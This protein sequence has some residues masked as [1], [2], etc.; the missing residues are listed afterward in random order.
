MHILTS[1]DFG[2]V[3][4]RMEIIAEA[5]QSQT[6]HHCFCAIGQGGATADRL[7]SL[8]A[9]V[10]CLLRKTSI[11]TFS[12]AVALYNHIRQIR[13]AVVHTHGA[14][15]NFHGLI[16]AWLARVPV[17]IGE[18]I[19]IPS[20]GTRARKIFAQVYRIAHRVVGISEAVTRWLIQSGEVPTKK[21]TRIYNP[22]ALQ[23]YSAPGSGGAGVFRIG[24]VGRLEPVKNPIALLEALQL[25][26]NSG[27]IAELWLVGDGSERG[28]LE[29]YVRVHGLCDQVKMLGFQPNPSVA[30]RECDVYVQPSISEGFGLA[31]VEAMG[32]GMPVIATAVGGAP[33]VIEHGRTGWLLEGATPEAIGEAIGHVARMTSV[34]REAVGRAAAEAVHGRFEPAAYLYE[35]ESLYLQLLDQRNGLR[36]G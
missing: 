33:E 17:R 22:V 24:F 7:V 11:P 13:P 34:D 31:L 23:Q 36:I 14:E 30:M 4:K 29:D 25:I 18:E 15:A 5:I 8:G 10:N 21:A 28:K 16:A 20:H 1:L 3:E 27:I 32:L 35:I 12:S 2:G 6:M 9:E 26:I 19:G